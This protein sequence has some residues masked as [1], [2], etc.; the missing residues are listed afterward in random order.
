MDL[1]TTGSGGHGP[2]TERDPQRVL[3]DVLDGRVSAEAAET[4]YGVVIQAGEVDVQAT[5]ELRVVRNEG[6]PPP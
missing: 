2:P 3:D 4:G 1:W 6:Q 5:E